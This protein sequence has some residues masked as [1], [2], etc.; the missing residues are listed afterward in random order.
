MFAR[1]ATFDWTDLDG[2]ERVTLWANEH[3]ADVVDWRFAGYAGGIALLDRDADPICTRPLYRS[4][5]VHR[6]VD[7]WDTRTPVPDVR[8]PISRQRRS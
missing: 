3:G 1:I 5:P 8:A 4:L 2:L 7:P 6:L